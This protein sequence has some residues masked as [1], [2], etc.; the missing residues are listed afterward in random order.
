MILLFTERL[1]PRMKYIFKHVLGNILGIDISFTAKIEKFISHKDPKFSY[2][3]SRMG[4]EFF[5]QKSGFLNQQGVNE[6]SLEIEDWDGVPCFFKIGEESDIPF[7]IFSASFYMLSRYE[8]FLPHVKDENGRFPATESLAYKHKFLTRPVVD[9]WAHKF[10]EALLNHFPDL[11]LSPRSFQAKNIMAVAEAYKYKRKGLMRN[12]GGGIRDL[13]YLR[14]IEV[15]ERINTQLFWAT[16]P[17]DIYRDLLKY[18]KQHKIAWSFMFQL[19]DYSRYNKNIG[20]NRLAYQALIKSMGDYGKIG[21]LLG[22]EA[23]SNVKILKKEKKR[24]ESIA[25]QELEQVLVNDYGLN[26][27]GLYNNFDAVEIGHDFSMGFIDK[28]G[29][30]A[31]TCTPFHYYELN[32]ERISPLLIHPTA[33]NSEAFKPSSFF[34]VKTILERLKNEVENV[35]GQLLML[36][37]NTDFSEEKR[38]E[39]FLQILEKMN[40]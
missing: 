35:N 8:E 10:K 20:H 22:Y 17:Y 39:K 40:E 23:T 28:I 11:K 13:F 1:T 2:G 12:V 4:N 26:L 16:D 32:L 7:D 31:G 19:S 5:I 38:R 18:S 37:K 3:K 15:F 6:I 29:F 27:P 21:L 25:N 14:F 24:W 9:I 30:R 36:Y 33:F 34:E